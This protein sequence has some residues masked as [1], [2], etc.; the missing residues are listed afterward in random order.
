MGNKHT[1]EEKK[2]KARKK[3]ESKIKFTSYTACFNFLERKRK[4][5]QIKKNGKLNIYQCPVC[6]SWH[7]GRIMNVKKDTTKI[8]KP[9]KK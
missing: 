1:E 3:C 8:L 2:R 4:K 6:F 5:G 7:F 9:Y